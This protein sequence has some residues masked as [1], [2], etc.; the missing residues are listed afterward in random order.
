[1]Q[2]KLLAFVALLVSSTDGIQ[3][4]ARSTQ[5]ILANLADDE[6]KAS[7]NATNGSNKSNKSNASNA[8]EPLEV[9]TSAADPVEW[10][11]VKLLGNNDG[12][13]AFIS[14]TEQLINATLST[15]MDIKDLRAVK[16]PRGNKRNKNAKFALVKDNGNDTQQWKLERHPSQPQNTWRLVDKTG[17]CLNANDPQDFRRNKNSAYVVSV[18]GNKGRCSFWTK[19]QAGNAW[20]IVL[21][22]KGRGQPA[23]KF[24]YM[25]GWG[26]AV[27]DHMKGDKEL[28]PEYSYLVLH[29]KSAKWSIWS[30]GIFAAPANVTANITAAA[31]LNA[32]NATENDTDDA[33]ATANATTPA[34]APAPAT[35]PPAAPAAGAAPAATNSSNASNSTNASNKTNKTKK[36]N[37][38]EPYAG[39]DDDDDDPRSV[40][41]T[42]DIDDQDENEEDDDATIR[43]KVMKASKMYEVPGGYMHVKWLKWLHLFE[44]ESD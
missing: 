27:L 2:I 21:A 30:G 25:F 41:L 22:N 39:N 1:M 26:L 40:D 32:T 4:T 36:K 24:N 5:S 20:N 16:R 19:V 9:E 38:P 33:N 15:H 8:T 44:T 23:G 34:A 6:V 35:P 10:S 31:A 3:M 28:G 37:L 13:T 11:Q 7:G 42:V 18:R 17:A 12:R 29:K 14:T 43:E